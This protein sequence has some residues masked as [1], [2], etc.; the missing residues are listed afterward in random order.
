MK[1]TS[2]YNQESVQYS[3]KRYPKI[4]TSYTQFFFNRRL[5]IAKKYLAQVV[6]AEQGKRLALLELGCADGVMVREFHRTFPEGF[7]K[8]VGIDVSSSMVEE[9]RKQN[10]IAEAKFLLRQEYSN[11]PVVDVINETGV[12]N[13]AGFDADIQFVSD[14]LKPGGW[15]ILSIAGTGSLRNKLKGEGGFKDFRSYGEYEKLLCEK[16]DILRV[17]GCGFFIPHI[18]KIPALARIIQ[19]TADSIFGRVL[20]GLCHEKVFL[21]RKKQ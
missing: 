18:W 7:L 10:T 12:I 15:Y 5:S 17:E 16:F 13:Y 2:F 9:A 6:E 21:L 3:S 4:P 14:N 19:G 20:P 11:R 1:D 8:L